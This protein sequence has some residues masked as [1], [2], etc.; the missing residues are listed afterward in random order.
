MKDK[1]WEKIKRAE[2]L[3]KKAQMYD[4]E[5]LSM[6]QEQARSTE[7]ETTQLAQMGAG[8]YA[9][10][11]PKQTLMWTSNVLVGEQ[12]VEQQQQFQQQIAEQ[13]QETIQETKQETQQW[14]QA[15]SDL[16]VD[17]KAASDND[18]E[19]IKEKD[20]NSDSLYLSEI[21]SLHLLGKGASETFVGLFLKQEE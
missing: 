21:I 16:P 10:V 4:D 12:E 14:A 17:S 19:V 1:I 5:A 18:N 8:P 11:D 9:S 7:Q 20:D 6:V 2:E 13:I 15:V 3:L